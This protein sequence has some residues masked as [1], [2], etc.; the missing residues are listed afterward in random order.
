MARLFSRR[1]QS[2]LLTLLALFLLGTVIVLSAV[3]AYFSIDQSAYIEAEELGTWDEIRWGSATDDLPLG[4]AARYPWLAKM[5]SSSSRSSEGAFPHSGP[6]QE[7]PHAA[8]PMT[9]SRDPSLD[10]LEKDPSAPAFDNT[11]KPW[12]PTSPKEKI[13]RIIHQTW[14]DS[15]LPG[16]WQ[17]VR[18]E[19]Q[20]MH[21][22]YEYMLW[23]DADSR[24]FLVEH[25][26]WFVPIF[27]A[28]PYAIQRAD[29]IRYFVLHKYGGIYMDLDVGCLRRFDPLL[30]F[31]VVLPKTI[32]VGVSNDIMLSAKGHPFM[33]QLIHN[34][35]TF[36]HRYLTNYPTVMFS[37]G[38]M[39]VSASYRIYVDAHGPA[40]PSSPSKPA[41]GFEGVRVLPKSLYGKNAKP[42]EAPNA[43]F[44]HFYGSSWH[45]NDAGFL[46][47]LRDYGKGLMLIGAIVVA[48]GFAK[49]LLPRLLH[50]LGRR[51]A[52]SS[53]DRRRRRGSANNG[54][55][56]APSSSA[57]RWISL[58]I[59]A[60]D[61]R[62]SRRAHSAAYGR[63]PDA[64]N[65]DPLDPRSAHNSLTRVAA[66]RPQRYSLPMFDLADGDGEADTGRHPAAQGL[67]SWVG[68]GFA[69]PPT[70]SSEAEERQ[71]AA[72][73]SSSSGGGTLYLPAFFVG[74]SSSTSSERA[75][76]SPTETAGWASGARTRMGSDESA[77]GHS[78]GS[79]L[80]T[81]A[82]GLLP[83][84]WRAASPS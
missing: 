6:A 49:T 56:A 75:R 65:S 53:A 32:P 19:C 71:V 10:A 80:G 5:L 13:P 29:A 55:G 20:A 37:T 33:D 73:G 44:K 41:A 43:F 74:G 36:N 58:P 26:S 78:R 54:G 14:K 38:P 50:S 48:Y 4:W 39:F 76:A 63:L 72:D 1:T 18:E 30:R 69:R 40:I 52:L 46:I 35:V 17:A 21:P 84:N 11:P 7:G 47:L 79:S 60:A 83:P 64:D 23:T 8:S 77:M 24:K 57:G 82:A 25:Y 66:P 31:E 45:A 22:D 2:V 51:S 59:R 16:K 67:L 81:W 9:G 27:D 34:L 28:Y 61:A 70:A 42:G 68:S 3:R 15:T 62:S 12:S